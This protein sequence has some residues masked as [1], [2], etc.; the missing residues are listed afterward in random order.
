M[1][2]E[3]EPGIILKEIEQALPKLKNNKVPGSN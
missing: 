2:D 3:K 1:S